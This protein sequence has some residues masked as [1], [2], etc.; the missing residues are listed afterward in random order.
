MRFEDDFIAVLY[1]WYF[2]LS[3][4]HYNEDFISNHAVPIRLFFNA[5]DLLFGLPLHVLT[6]FQVVQQAFVFINIKGFLRDIVILRDNG[7][8]V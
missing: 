2:F 4:L 7:Y 8:Q 1:F 5:F 3:I 6:V